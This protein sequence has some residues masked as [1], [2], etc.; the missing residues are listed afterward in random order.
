MSTREKF[1]RVVDLGGNNVRIADYLDGALVNYARGQVSNVGQL[2][3]FVCQKLAGAQG[4][5]ISSAGLISNNRVMLQSPNIPWLDKIDLAGLVENAHH[6]PARIFNDMDGA[7]MGMYRLMEVQ[8][9][10]GQRASLM[11]SFLGLTVSSGVGGRFV[12]RGGILNPRAEMSHFIIDAS[13]HAPLCGHGNG[14]CGLRGCV[15]SFVGGESVKLEVIQNC[16]ILGIAIPLGMHPCA[17]LDQQFDE[18]RAWAVAI[19]NKLADNLAKF[20]AVILTTVGLT[21]VVYKGTLGQSA[22]PRIGPRIISSMRNY[23][24]TGMQQQIER[25]NFWPSPDPDNDALIG[26]ALLFD[27]CLRNLE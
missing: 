8:V 11:E 14:G 21:D 4:V 27:R 9:E 1:L 7:V 13:M 19:Y 3:E 22:F 2:I 16:V 12:Y 15:E 23:L 24:M 5:A 10:R 17:F 18:N 6:V 25:L 26:S 20:F